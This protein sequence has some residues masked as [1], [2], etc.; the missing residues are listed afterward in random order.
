MAVTQPIWHLSPASTATAMVRG[1]T[2]Q[3][4]RVVMRSFLSRV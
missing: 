4:P 1:G 3:M 2:R